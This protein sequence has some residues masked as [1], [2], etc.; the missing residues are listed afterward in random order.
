MARGAALEALPVLSMAT[1]IAPDGALTHAC[2]Q[3]GES[4]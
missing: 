4:Q 2:D 3:I 1:V